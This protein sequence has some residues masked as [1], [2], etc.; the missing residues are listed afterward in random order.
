MAPEQ[1]RAEKSLSTAVDVYALGAILYQALTGRPPFQADTPLNTILQVLERDPARPVNCDR[2]LATIALKC[3]EKEPAKRYDSAAA[4]ADELDRWQKGEPILA[5][6]AGA[7]ERGWKW[8]KRRPAAAGLIGVSL[9]AG[10]ALAGGGLY[11]NGL[12]VV[13]EMQLRGQQKEVDAER[14]RMLRLY[15]ARSDMNL[16]DGKWRQGDILETYKVLASIPSDLRNWEWGYKLRRALGSAMT[17]WGHR[18]PVA[19]SPDGSELASYSADGMVRLCDLTKGTVRLTLS[20]ADEIYYLTFSPDGTRLA[21][22][23]LFSE[24]RVRLWDTKTG[25]L[26]LDLGEGPSAVYRAAFSPD[27]NR[28]ASCGADSTVRV[29]DVIAGAAIHTLTGHTRDVHTIAFS[30]DGERLVSGSADRTVRLWNAKTGE[31]LLTLTGHNDQVWSVAC[32]PDNSRLASAS[33]DKSVRLWDAKTGAVLQSIAAHDAGARCVAFSPDGMRLA[34]SSDDTKI[35][36]WDAKTGAALETLVGHTAFVRNVSFSADGARLFSASRDRTVK[37]WRVNDA[38]N[39]SRGIEGAY[40]TVFSSDGARLIGWERL[41]SA[42]NAVKIWDARTGAVLR[43]L[44]RHPEPDGWW[45][46]V[47]LSPDGARWAV[48]DSRSEAMTLCDMKNVRGIELTTRFSKNVSGAFSHD[49]KRFATSTDVGIMLWD[50]STGAQLQTLAAYPGEVHGLA[51]S[52]DGTRLAGCGTAQ[53]VSIWDTKSGAILQTLDGHNSVL[54]IVAFSPDGAVLVSGDKVG[55]INIWNLKDGSLTR[56]LTGHSGWIGSL[57][58]NPDGTR[59][60][61]WSADSVRIWDPTDGALLETLN[62]SKQERTFSY[63]PDSLSFNPDGMHLLWGRDSPRGL[64]IWNVR[65]S[66]TIFPLTGHKDGNL[67]AAFSPNGQYLATGSPREGTVKLWDVNTGAALHTFVEFG[68]HPTVEFSPDGECLAI[69]GGIG[70]VTIREVKTGKKL[71]TLTFPDGK[72]PEWISLAFSPDGKRLASRQGGRLAVWVLENGTP[73]TDAEAPEWFRDRT[74]RTSSSNSERFAVPHPDGTILLV[75]PLP[76]DEYE[77][78][79]RAWVSRP[80]PDWHWEQAEKLERGSSWF[81][82]AFHC[83]HVLKSRPDDERAKQLLQKAREK[84]H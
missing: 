27:G 84:A 62:K 1:A 45:D 69:P 28:L 16:A 15:T 42:P 36:I 30:S 11:F 25:E 7:A 24:K 65:P 68:N 38:D 67:C 32:S 73:I 59:L 23:G 4:L 49:G 79:Y 57:A 18:G 33:Q 74:S 51:F 78:G 12:L 46:W 71:Q 61:S 72:F 43:T 20:G 76:P 82:V 19:F 8:V 53:T 48:F 35:K 50:T 37:V 21:A 39:L 5:R 75:K 55:T 41:I 9:L 13:K 40:K 3:L 60:A 31:A 34:S 54:R 22:C 52:P 58:F 81:A 70:Q 26:K 14:Q 10:V 83:E 29:W 44:S 56:T 64:Q 63:P 47:E 77:L 66:A 6:P 80:D 17:L 2:D